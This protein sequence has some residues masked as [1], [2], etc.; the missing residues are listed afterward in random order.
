MSVHAQYSYLNIGLQITNCYVARSM[1]LQT[2]LKSKKL[3]QAKFAKEIGVSPVAVLYW[4]SGERQPGGANMAKIT[5]ATDAL[6]TARDIQ[7]VLERK[8][9]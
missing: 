3:T 2:Y 9:T 4:C 6:V 5:K 7:S 1:D 8:I